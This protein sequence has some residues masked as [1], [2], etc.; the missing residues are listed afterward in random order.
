MYSPFRSPEI[1][2]LKPNGIIRRQNAH[3]VDDFPRPG[4]PK[5][6]MFGLVTIFLRTH[7]GG[8]V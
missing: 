6:I 7:S 5:I 1:N 4:L 3:T 8:W 2:V